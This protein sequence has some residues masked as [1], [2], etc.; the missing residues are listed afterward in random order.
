VTLDTNA[1]S[2]VAC[3]AAAPVPVPA[4]PWIYV[5]LLAVGLAAAGYFRL[6]RPGRAA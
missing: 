2:G 3:T 1:V 6:R 5:V 4:L